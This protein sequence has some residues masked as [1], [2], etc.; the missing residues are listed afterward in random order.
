MFS[1]ILAALAFTAATANAA[2]ANYKKSTHA[3][4]NAAWI[5]ADSVANSACLN[6]SDSEQ[7]PIDL[8]GGAEGSWDM[9]VKLDLEKYAN[10][11]NAAYTKPSTVHAGI[12][13]GEMELT[14]NGGAKDQFTVLQTHVHGPSEH[15]VDGEMYDLEMHFVHK[16]TENDSLG[17]ARLGA[18]L[19]VFFDRTAGGDV[20]NDFIE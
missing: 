8:T 14:F 17:E 11:P 20:D 10:E 12:S 2:G 1:K 7:S 4:V 9:G 13:S 3:D 16:Y 19:G 18:V 6:K 5:A 15:T